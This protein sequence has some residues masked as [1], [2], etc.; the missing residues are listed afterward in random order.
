MAEEEAVEKM[1]KDGKFGSLGVIFYLLILP[2]IIY[3]SICYFRI[4]KFIF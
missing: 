4:F 1:V 2:N 3:L